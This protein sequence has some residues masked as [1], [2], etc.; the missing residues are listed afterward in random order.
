MR[1]LLLSFTL[2]FAAG[3][4]HRYPACHLIYTADGASVTLEA[5]TWAPG[6][7][8]VDVNGES[9]VVTLPG[10]EDLDCS[11]HL[12]LQLSADNAGIDALRFTESA[13]ATLDIEL[14]RDGLEFDSI[15]L[16]PDYLTTEPNGE[17]CGEQHWAVESAAIQGAP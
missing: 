16:D 15:S 4:E 1:T 2:S 10:G 17:G 11:E 12:S 3:C 5:D 6:L 9:C 14:L 13:P 7:Y 8:Q